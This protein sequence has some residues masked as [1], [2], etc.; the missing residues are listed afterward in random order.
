MATAI[1]MLA[2][3]ATAVTQAHSTNYRH[4]A[5]HAGSMSSRAPRELRPWNIPGRGV[6]G[7][8]SQFNNPG[9]Q[10]KGYGCLA[11]PDYGLHTPHFC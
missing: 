8:A 4:H 6:V 1:V 3:A 7:G 11:H 5:G 10:I 9:S 2:F